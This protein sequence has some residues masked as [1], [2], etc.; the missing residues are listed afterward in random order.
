[1]Q[2]RVVF[3]AAILVM[4]VGRLV[5]V[6]LRF[7]SASYGVGQLAAGVVVSIFGFWLILSGR[8]K[9]KS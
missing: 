6:M 7:E 2:W 4:G 3:G 8:Q 5:L 1:M 9:A